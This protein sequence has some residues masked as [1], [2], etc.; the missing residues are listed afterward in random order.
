MKKIAWAL[1][2]PLAFAGCEF[3]DRVPIEMVTAN[4]IQP[5]NQEKT[6]D[7]SVRLDVGTLEIGSEKQAGS[8]YSY[9]LLYDKSSFAPET[10]YSSAL[11]GTEGRLFI[12]L[13]N[14]SQ[15]GIHPQRNDNKL[16]IDFNDSIPLNLKVTAGIGEARLSLSGLKISRIDVESGVGAT[17][18][19]AYEPNAIPCD[20]V[21]LKSGVGSFE[22]VGLGNLNFRDL[23]FEGGLGGV[24]L[25]FTGEWKHNADIRM[26]V[27]VGEVRVRMPKEIG[28]K[29]EAAKNFLSG[30]SLEGFTKQDPYHFSSNYD[31]APIRIT[32]HITNGLGGFRLTWL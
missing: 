23:E 1:C 4:Q 7:S 6:L 31:R 26:R 2:L 14:T 25:D 8:L 16:H 28:V 5:L 15:A 27:G 3:V 19:S 17:K 18:I 30:L 24:T 21:R 9:D 12:S 22:A 13:Q 29:V 32:F 10:H 11:G 20:S